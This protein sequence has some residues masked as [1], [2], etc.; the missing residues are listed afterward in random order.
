MTPLKQMLTQYSIDS[1]SFDWNSEISL[2]YE[3]NKKTK[4]ILKTFFLCFRFY[5]PVLLLLRRSRSF[6]LFLVFSLSMKK[7]EKKIRQK[8]TQLNT[9]FGKGND[10]LA[11]SLKRIRCERNKVRRRGKALNDT[12]ALQKN[13]SD[14]INQITKTVKLSGLS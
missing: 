13:G 7:G 11:R 3:S 9:I 2:K 14:S 8:N 1:S 4:E 10:A 5:F 6:F 12:F